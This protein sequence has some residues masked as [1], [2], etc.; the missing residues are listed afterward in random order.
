MKNIPKFTS[1]AAALAVSRVAAAVNRADEYRAKAQECEQRAEQTLDSWAKGQF[2]DCADHWKS[3]A[4]Q[5]E[6]SIQ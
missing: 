6:R 2:R 4:K 3:L 5:A 1:L